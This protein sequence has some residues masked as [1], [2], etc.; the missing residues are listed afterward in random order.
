MKN[1]QHSL[2]QIGQTFF[3]F[4]WSCIYQA[5]VF[6]SAYFKVQLLFWPVWIPCF[7]SIGCRKGILTWNELNNCLLTTYGILCV[8]LDLHI[9]KIIACLI[10]RVVLFLYPFS[11]PIHSIWK[12]SIF[13]VSFDL[14]KAMSIFWQKRRLKIPNMLHL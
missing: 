12:T 8:M 11:F 9:P 5:N 4:L 10:E 14:S 2:V 6:I 7:I 13:E 3:V 1:I